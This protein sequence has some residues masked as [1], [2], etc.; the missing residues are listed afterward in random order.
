MQH[1]LHLGN[2]DFRQDTET[3]LNEQ[4]VRQARKKE[5]RAPK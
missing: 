4:L 5:L 2:T 1:G 3:N